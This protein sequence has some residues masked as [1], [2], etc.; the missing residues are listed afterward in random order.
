M[1]SRWEGESAQP[2]LSQDAPWGKCS[3]ASGG[4]RVYNWRMSAV[5]EET[6]IIAKT[7]EL[8]AEIVADPSF[9]ENQAKVERF[10][11]DD[12]ARLQYQS[13]HERGDELA[14]KQRA[15]IELSKSE[16]KEFE[17]ARDALFANEVARD[18]LEAQRALEQ[19]QAEIGKYVGATIELGRVATAEDIS[20]S[21][22]CCGGGGCGC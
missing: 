20:E 22:G 7:Q 13:V 8:C 18:F 19:I 21:G 11:A 9:R 5:A 6:A 14:H 3:V 10:L 12:A 17:A 4:G 1:E 16:V 15:G 2:N